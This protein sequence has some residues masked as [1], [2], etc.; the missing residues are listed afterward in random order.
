MG[1]T[2]F[3]YGG[4]GRK[5]GE[6]QGT[7]GGNFPPPRVRY[8]PPEH[9][10][11]LS[12]LEDAFQLPK[13]QSIKGA[14]DRLELTVILELLHLSC[15]LKGWLVLVPVAFLFLIVLIVGCSHTNPYKTKTVAFSCS[16]YQIGLEPDFI[17]T[18]ATAPHLRRLGF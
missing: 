2:A 13:L 8:L 12:A 6:V 9:V 5:L 4:E 7:P 1:P 10:G 17:T 11:E 16:Y 3:D 15:G 18:I 14:A